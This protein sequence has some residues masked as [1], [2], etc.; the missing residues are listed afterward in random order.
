LYITDLLLIF[1]PS[2][3]PAFYM[4]IYTKK[5]DRGQTSVFDSKSARLTRISKDSLRVRAIGAVDELDSFLGFAKSL[6]YDITVI[7]FITDIQRDL[8]TIGSKLAGSKLHLSKTKTKKLEKSIDEWEGKLPVL[9]NFIL[10]GGTPLGAYLHI[11]RSAA[12]RAEREVTAL[13][14]VEN[15]SDNIKSYLNR[16]SDFLFMLS[17]KVNHDAG[18][19]EEI[20][21]G[22]KK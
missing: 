20:W 19:K 3:A 7:N 21:V 9:S 16:L 5:G 14:Q 4:A 12:R 10:P 22:K 17:R 8:L 1:D 18:I 13:S 11:C 2:L 6:S 15:V